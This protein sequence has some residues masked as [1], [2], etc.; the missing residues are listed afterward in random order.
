[1]QADHGGAARPCPP[2]EITAGRRE[3]LLESS[4]DGL[5]AVDDKARLAFVLN[6]FAELCFRAGARE[7]AQAAAAEALAVAS[8]LG[9]ST[10]IIVA[11]AL[12]GRLAAAAGDE[13][14][15]EAHTATARAQDPI[16]VRSARARLHLEQAAQA[17]GQSGRL[18]VHSGITD[19][20]G[21]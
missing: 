12:L 10:E 4:L 15:A 18:P 13:R 8:V 11:H 17:I 21:S 9:R 6:T 1:M 20:A 16:D 3:T 19:A 2:R 14:S 7:P 5:R